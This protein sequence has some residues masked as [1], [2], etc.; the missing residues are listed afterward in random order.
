MIKLYGLLSYPLSDKTTVQAMSG[1]ILCMID[2]DRVKINVSKATESYGKVDLRRLQTLK[3]NNIESV[4]LL[5]PWKQGQY[6]EQTVI[7][8][9][10][11]PKTFYETIKEII[12]A[13][14]NEDIQKLF[15]LY[16]FNP[17]IKFSRIDGTA[18]LLI[19]TNYEAGSEK[20]KLIQFL[21][22]KK[23][24]TKVAK[25]YNEKIKITPPDN[26]SLAELIM[27]YFGMSNPLKPKK[28]EVLI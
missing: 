24:K 25:L 13:N 21:A 7:E 5:E 20:E 22:D 26:N 27:D 12:N 8:D 19:P 2:T 1:K 23:I 17:N 4:R 28:N 10:L 18:S 3:S 6:Y 11:D 15:T 9:C 14:A 16:S